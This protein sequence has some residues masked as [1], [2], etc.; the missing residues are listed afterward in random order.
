LRQLVG[1]EYSVNKRMLGSVFAIAVALSGCE[2]FAVTFAP[3]KQA[4]TA[5]SAAT[6]KA[7][8]LF[9]ETLHGAQYERIPIALNALTA[10]YLETP[11]DAVTAAHLGW[12]H[13]WRITERARLDN[14]PATITDDAVLA[15]KYF[16]E[17]VEL[18]PRDARYLGFLGSSTLVEAGIH[19]DEPLTRQG[20]FTLL[21]SIK[22]WPEFNLFTAGYTTSR[23]PAGS[24]EF[25]QALA[26]QWENLDLCA[27]EKIDRSTAAYAK[28]M[29]LSTTEGIKRVCWNS[30]I[31][32]HNLEGFFLNMGDMLVKAGD[33]QTAQKVYANARLVP[34]YKLWKY[35]DVLEK[36]INDAQTNVEAFNAQ[37]SLGSTPSNTIM[38]TSTFS[39]MACHQQ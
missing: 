19:Q 14:V 31:A 1:K 28:Y 38:V 15:R 3:Q 24:K 34:E 25:A 2:Y 9:W 30:W 21:K 16:T 36:R 4:A 12:L 6:T 18:D 27:G 7:D 26:W 13:I 22:A 29:P 23:K 37:V 10:A 32:P 35:R 39:C 11:N 8:E 17:A 20:Y 33:W 5:R